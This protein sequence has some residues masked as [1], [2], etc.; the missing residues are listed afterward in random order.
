MDR[1]AYLGVLNKM[2]RQ[3]S[4][5]KGCHS[6]RQKTR[7]LQEGPAPGPEEALDGPERGPSA[8][9]AHATKDCPCSQRGPAPS[10]SSPLR[11][12]PRHLACTEQQLQVHHVVDD[13]LHPEK[14]E[15]ECELSAGICLHALSS[16]SK[17]IMLSNCSRRAGQ[18]T[19]RASMVRTGLV[20]GVS[21]R[22]QVM[23]VSCT[24]V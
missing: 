14:C 20:T 6:C 5:G 4:I 10:C 1:L 8:P 9:H 11:F 15:P 24:Q 7:A 3:Q 19:W 12:A 17:F 23:K 21:T 22:P 18:H 16:S 13:D 2:G